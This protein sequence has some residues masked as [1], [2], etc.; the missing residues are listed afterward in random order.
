MRLFD[1]ST[2]QM[3]IYRGGW[4]RP[5]APMLPSG[6]SV[7]DAEARATIADLITALINAG[8]LPSS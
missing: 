5:A 7:V 6:G 1:R 2:A 4:Q 3:I 8:I